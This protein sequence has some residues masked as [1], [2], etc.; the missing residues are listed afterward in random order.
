[1]MLMLMVDTWSSVLGTENNKNDETC[2]LAQG[3]Y[4]SLTWEQNEVISGLIEN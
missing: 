3:L 1:M 4:Y 2:E